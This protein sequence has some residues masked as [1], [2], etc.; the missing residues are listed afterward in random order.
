VFYF[1]IFKKGKMVMKTDNTKNDKIVYSGKA[2]IELDAYKILD[3]PQTATP[4]EVKKAYLRL[5]KKW[6]PDQETLPD[7]KE[8]SNGMLVDINAA[9]ELLKDPK[10]R[11]EYDQGYASFQ[12]KTKEQESKE[13][14]RINSYNNYYNVLGVPPNV[15]DEEMRI[16]ARRLLN[17]WHPDKHP[18]NREVATTVSNKVNEAYETLK[19]PE[20]RE[21]HTLT[22]PFEMPPEEIE[23][24]LEEVT[25]LKQTY[26]VAQGK[27]QD[28]LKE[29][30]SPKQQEI[31]TS[32]EDTLKKNIRDLD[33]DIDT[34]KFAEHGEGFNPKT[35]QFGK[36]TFEK[37]V[38]AAIKAKDFDAPTNKLFVYI[39]ELTR[40]KSLLEKAHIPDPVFGAIR[41]VRE[42]FDALK[43]QKQQLSDLVSPKNRRD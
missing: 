42:N 27:I 5:V 8:F 23:K 7:T 26:E 22:V 9:Y 39:L 14:N 41:K 12:K 25:T 10:Q 21:Y 36:E 31:L 1:L 16:V 15:T 17:K 28:M 6:H 37:K 32:M 13:A 38:D 4:E 40:G 35:V 24:H 3:I 18:D 20:K 19:D 11:A 29:N 2:T 43:N 34:L 30:L 33:I